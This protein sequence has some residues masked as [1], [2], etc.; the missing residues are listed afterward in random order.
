MERSKEKRTILR[1]LFSVKSEFPM[2]VLVY[3]RGLKEL[4]CQPDSKTISF[5]G[6][7]F[8]LATSSALFSFGI[9][10]R[11]QRKNL[12]V[13][14]VEIGWLVVQSHYWPGFFYIRNRYLASGLVPSTFFLPQKLNM[15][16]LEHPRNQ[17]SRCTIEK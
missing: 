17:M 12:A 7:F 8:H 11:W 13:A 4:R 5:S 16:S 2:A 10:F 1:V 3:R 9:R 14:P 15:T 6:Q